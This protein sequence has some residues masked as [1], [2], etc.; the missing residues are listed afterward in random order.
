MNPLVGMKVLDLTDGN[1]YVTVMLADYGAEVVKIERPGV[2]DSNR[3]LGP[4]KDGEGI[5]QPYYNRGKKSVTLDLEQPE[6]REILRKMV[7]NFDVVVENMPLGKMESLGLGYEEL[8]KLNPKLV[9]G[10]I[11]GWGTKGPWKDYPAVDLLV[12]AKTGFISFTGFPEKPSV[13]GY[14]VAVFYAANYLAA[15]IV[16]ACT[17]A[18]ETGI[19]QKVEVSLWESLLSVHE[20]KLLTHF[21]VNDSI[22][23]IGNSYPTVQPT[24]TYKCKDG[25]F[26]LSVGTDKHWADL[27]REMGW[28]DLAEVE[29]YKYDPDR[30]MKYYWGD[31]EVELKK[32][33]AEVTLEEA[34]MGCRR[35]MVPGGPVNTI[36]E[37][38]VDE[39][40]AVHKMLLEVDDPRYGKILQLG[41]NK[42]YHQDNEHD[43]ELKPA[44]T[45]GQNNDEIFIGLLGMSEAELSAL[46]AKN[47]I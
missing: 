1:G 13:I 31:L 44:P 46:K 39:Q 36:K 20:D 15:G 19:G 41:K 16:A 21:I 2:G 17:Y 43:D 4:Q 27:C 40:V 45:L 33:Y 26:S 32:R 29:R 3:K 30:S 28:N 47:V 24:E 5:Y 23:R 37:L 34:D 12:Q 25:W 18:E 11:T 22:K 6:G 9:Y 38:L 7:P 42:K 14:P 8:E 10:S 35:A